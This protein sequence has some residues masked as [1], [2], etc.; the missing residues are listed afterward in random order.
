MEIPDEKISHIIIDPEE[1][2]L[3]EDMRG[4][5][6]NIISQ[7]EVNLNCNGRRKIKWKE[8]EIIQEKSRNEMAD[9]KCR[10]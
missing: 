3:K 6:E 7:Q 5:Q 10:K 8:K 1:T 2:Y 9:P 4:N